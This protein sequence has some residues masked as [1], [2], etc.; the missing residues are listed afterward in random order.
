MNDKID[1]GLLYDSVSR[2]TGDI[3]MGIAA[4]QLLTA[5]GVGNVI[6]DPFGPLANSDSPMII[7]GGELIRTAGDDFYDRFRP[8]GAHIL[9]AAGIWDRADDLD[10][11]R[12][13]AYVSARS[14]REAET[15]APHADNVEVLP[16]STTI[17]RSEHYEIPGLE[18][19]EP[20][21]GIHLVPHSLRLVDD[22][23]TLINAIPYRKV[24]IPFTHYNGDESF[25]RSLFDMTDAIM[26][27]KL[28]PLQLHSV[29][30]Q[31]RFTVVS[32]LHASIFSYG[33]NVPF[34]SIHQRKAEY[35]FRD[36]GLEGQL[37]RD[38]AEFTS[39]LERAGSGEMDFTARIDADATLINDA[40]DRYVGLLGGGFPAQVEPTEQEQARRN[41]LYLEQAERVIADHDLALGSVEARRLATLG[42]MRDIYASH[43]QLE[44]VIAEQ[45]ARIERLESVLPI[46]AARKLGLL[47]GSG[48]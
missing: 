2:N 38:N 32:S 20:V 47:R 35:Y 33:Q 17:M 25:M 9:N 16:C 27:P 3:A 26:L 24:F 19:G 12:D 34:V 1:A 48:V 40:Y 45:Q 8:R 43:L 22:L 13:Y 14:S 41:A 11:L 39:A 4:E 29:L 15:L 7:G 31:M 46:R 28:E 6:V 23:L 10:Y 30:G 5:R 18:A 42:E 21:V 37:V 36:R 44:A